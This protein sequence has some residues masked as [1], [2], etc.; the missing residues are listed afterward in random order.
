MVWIFIYLYYIIVNLHILQLVTIKIN[1]L[2]KIKYFLGNQKLKVFIHKM[3]YKKTHFLLH[4][5]LSN[6]CIRSRLL[7]IIRKLVTIASTVPQSI[8]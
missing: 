5:R 3:R 1:M 7:K 4:L 6:K 8:E 2:T